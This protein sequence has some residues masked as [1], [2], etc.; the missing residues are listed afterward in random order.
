LSD[1]IDK[2]LSTKS[3]KDKTAAKVTPKKKTASSAKSGAEKKTPKKTAAK[4]TSVSKNRQTAAKIAQIAEN[5]AKKKKSESKS[6]IP[7]KKSEKR[8]KIDESAEKAERVEKKLKVMCLGGLGTIGENLTV[9]EY[10]DDIIVVDC[11]MGFPDDDMFGVELVIPDFTYLQNNKE[12]IRGV[13]LTHGHEDHIGSVPYLLKLM[14]VPIYGTRLT[15]G[16]V[17]NK[18]LDFKLDFEAGLFCVEAGEIVKAGV[19]SVEFIRVNHSIADACCF[20]IKTPIGYVV[21]SGDF[22]LDLTPVDGDIM[23]ISRLGEIGQKGVLLLM[24]E[25]TNADRPGYTPSEK[26]IGKTF[27]GIF[28]KY[29]DKRIVVATFSSNVHRVQQ[30]IDFSVAYGRKVALTGRSMLSIVAAASELGYMNIPNGTLI[31]I[32]EAKRFKP[33]EVTV[34]TTGSQGEHMSGLYRMAFSEHRMIELGSDDLVVISANAIPGNEKEVDRIIN[35]LSKNGISV[36]CDKSVPIHVSGHACQEEL[37]LMHALLKPRYFMP[38]H[39]EHKHLSAHVDIAKSMGMEAPDIFVGENGRVLEITPRKA[40][41]GK[42]VQSGRVLIDGSGIGDVGNI[43]LRDRRHLAEDGIVVVTLC[44]SLEEKLLLSGPEIV[45][46]G[47]VYVRENEDL[48]EFLRMVAIECIFDAFD[49][50]ITEW[51]QVKNMLKDELSRAVFN[52]TRRRPMVLPIV[53]EGC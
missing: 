44:A 16:I 50:N 27:D 4:S 51:G 22:K 13:F 12:K 38:I 23:D 2:F 8:L 31:D 35:E 32:S 29:A 7:V 33:S 15:L 53:L 42:S 28:M 19:F 25:S 49:R 48:M 3:E 52:K 39:G 21:H 30:I 1:S 47:F 10:G 41:W 24:C 26:T 14:N 20:A 45:S 34:I 46:R 18:L 36:F 40:G 9:L 37:K 5:P 11:G 6:D 43:V 17:S